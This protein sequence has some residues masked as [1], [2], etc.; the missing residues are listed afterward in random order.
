[1]PKKINESDENLV[2]CNQQLFVEVC[3][4]KEATE[5]S[6]F[7]DLMNDIFNLNEIF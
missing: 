7:D 6:S 5:K 1:M 4:F 2:R 3:F